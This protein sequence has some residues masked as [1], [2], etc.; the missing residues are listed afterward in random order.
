MEVMIK[1]GKAGDK[2]GDLCHNAQRKKAKFALKHQIHQT[3]YTKF[4]AHSKPLFGPEIAI[5]SKR[6]Q[7]VYISN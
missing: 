4:E 1:V 5:V 7:P 6:I 2:F 3:F